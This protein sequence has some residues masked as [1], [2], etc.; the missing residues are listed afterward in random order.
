MSTLSEVEFDLRT[1]RRIE[2]NKP[3][4][5]EVEERKH[6][7][8]CRGIPHRH[9]HSHSLPREHEPEIPHLRTDSSAYSDKWS[10]IRL[11]RKS[12]K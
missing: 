1:E 9:M 2:F 11:A 4:E 5:C 6:S 12:I 10:K 8:R 7:S 3:Y